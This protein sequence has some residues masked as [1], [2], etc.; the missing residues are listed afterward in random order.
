MLLKLVRVLRQMSDTVAEAAAL[1]RKILQSGAILTIMLGA[2]LPSIHIGSRLM[3]KVTFSIFQ[4]YTMRT[5]K[6]R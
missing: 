5:S 6:I 2:H 3:S 1:L 4:I